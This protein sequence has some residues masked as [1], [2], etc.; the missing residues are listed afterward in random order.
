MYTKG[1]GLGGLRR[2][3]LPCL[4]ARRAPTGP[5][6]YACHEP[7][8][9]RLWRPSQC[10]RIAGEKGATLSELLVSRL[11]YTIEELMGARAR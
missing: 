6:P 7:P 1:G 10:D 4:Q 9:L 5:T 3:S 11:S 8:T 2:R